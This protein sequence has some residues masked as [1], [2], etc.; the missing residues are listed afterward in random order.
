MTSREAIRMLDEL[1][2]AKG[3]LPAHDTKGVQAVTDEIGRIADDL[4][5]GLEALQAAAAAR[6]ARRG[7]GGGGKGASDLGGDDD[8]EDDEDED[9]LDKRGDDGSTA[10]RVMRATIA[11]NKRC[12]LAYVMHRADRVE[13]MRW[14]SGSVLSPEQRAKLSSEEVDHFKRA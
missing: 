10:L 9:E 6:A 12:L 13:L 1:E 4:R 14:M 5:A 11:R 7:G 3:P 2:R 8:D